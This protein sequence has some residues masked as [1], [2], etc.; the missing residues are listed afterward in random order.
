V[1]LNEPYTVRVNDMRAIVKD[2]YGSPDVLRYEEMPAPV[3]SDEQVLVRVHA[4]SV[5]AFDWH[6]LRGK[7][8]IAR[9]GEGLWAPK[10]RQLGLDVAGIAEAVGASVTDVKPGERVFGSRFGAFAE[11]V[12]GKNMVRMPANL[13]F[14]QAAAVPT[15]GLTAL[16]GLRD[17]GGL[18]AGQKVLVNG[19]GGGVGTMAVQIA[20]ALGAHVTAVSSTRNLDLLQSIGA[21][22]VVDYSRDDFTRARRGYD[23]ILDVGGN[24]RLSHL[25]RA[26]TADGTLVMVA[27]QPGQWIGPIARMVGAAVTTRIGRRPAIGYLATG[28]RDDLVF[29]RDLIEAGTVRPVIDRTYRFEEIPAAIR[30]VE[31]GRARGKVVITFD[32]ADGP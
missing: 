32:A 10:E 17:K 2:R 31:E 20:R 21:D 6:M 11:Y 9:L 16:Q 23:L 5:N 28:N 24:R 27:P 22:D 7:P 26:L 30:H 19:A 13:S 4:S 15:V 1:L 8:Y 14:E 29:L 12:A 3:P 18:Q 25:R